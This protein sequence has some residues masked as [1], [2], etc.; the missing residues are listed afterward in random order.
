MAL[1]K[2]DIKK[3]LEHPIQCPFCGGIDVNWHPPHMIVFTV[4][5]AV[6]CNYCKKSWRETYR[7]ETIEEIF[8]E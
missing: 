2:E 3:Y 5:V 7:I 6:T 1:S 4:I 8:D